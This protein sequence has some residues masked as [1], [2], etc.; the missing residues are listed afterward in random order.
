MDP[1]GLERAFAGVR[2]NARVIELDRHQP[3]FTM[4]WPQ[5][6]ARIVS[7]ARVARGRPLYGQYRGLIGQVGARYGV[8]PGVI[9]G[10]W[11]IES[12]FGRAMGDYNVIEAVATLAWEG[13][14]GKFFRSELMDALRILDRGDIAPERM[15]GSWAG[16]MGQTQFMPDSFL[17]YA[18]DYD[19]DGRRDLW[20]DMPDIFASTA[21]CLARTGWRAGLPWGV[22]VAL[23]PGLDAAQTGRKNRRPVAAWAAAGVRPL[24]GGSLGPEDA[25]AAIVLPGGAGDEAFLVYTANFQAIRSYNPSDYYCCAVGLLGDAVTA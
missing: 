22:A 13:R 5:Y 19:G 17:Q 14:R 12:D 25:A 18:V 23:P 9:V 1:A 21:N 11:G 2:I 20:T 24:R 3:E 4:T 8:T 16:A 15:T 10:I 6:R 7:D